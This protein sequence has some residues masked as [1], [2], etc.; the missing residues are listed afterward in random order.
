MLAHPA[1]VECYTTMFYLSYYVPCS[2][3]FLVS[4]SKLYSII[5]TCPPQLDGFLW[6]VP[7][8]S[9]EAL[10]RIHSFVGSYYLLGSS[11]YLDLA[12]PQYQLSVSI[13]I[14]VEH[15]VREQLDSLCGFLTRVR[16]AD[17]PTPPQ[18]IA[19]AVCVD[20]WRKSTSRRLNDKRDVTTLWLLVKKKNLHTI[21]LWTVRKTPLRY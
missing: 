16:C 10:C 12:F 18:A 14:N 4:S 9:H 1:Y 19:G 11:I 21:F 13:V 3:I 15:A 20:L 2:Y 5:E 6:A 17:H 8:H 7:S